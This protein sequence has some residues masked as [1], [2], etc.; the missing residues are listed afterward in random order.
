[1]E[2]ADTFFSLCSG[3]LRKRMLGVLCDRFRE[4]LEGQN[5]INWAH[6]A[7]LYAEFGED[8]FAEVLQV[9]MSEVT[10]GLAALQAAQSP[11]E[12]R[13]SFHFLKGAALNL[14]FQDVAAICDE[15]EILAARNAD[16]I[17][18][19]AEV[20]ILFPSTFARFEQEWRDRITTAG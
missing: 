19:K 7:E 8:G 5:M 12:H 20:M 18:Q 17:S 6:V 1:M 10:E 4:R 14:G 16:F 9:F 11:G 13:N 15:G 2:V 3:H